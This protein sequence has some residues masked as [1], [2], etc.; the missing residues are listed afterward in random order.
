MRWFEDPKKIVEVRKRLGLTQTALAKLSKIDR[1]IIANIETGRRK[2]ADDIS[3]RLWE[4][5]AAVEIER[6]K[7]TDKWQ[8]LVAAERRKLDERF[9]SLKRQPDGLP[10]ATL[11]GA[12][13][14]AKA[15]ADYQESCR[16]MEQQ[17]GPRWREVFREIADLQREK[18]DLEERI[19][20]SEKRLAEL[21]DLLAIE[22]ASALKA[23]EAKELRQR[24]AKKETIPP[25]RD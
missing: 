7:G 8:K 18:I 5:L 1:A 19:A 4:T 24:I 22:T 16:Q 15:F 25:E 2:F 23:S 12:D 14:G 11:A 20:D 6:M 10:L 3:K 9:N 17:Y 21:R 13:T